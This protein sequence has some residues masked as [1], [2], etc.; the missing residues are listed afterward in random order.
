MSRTVC[1]LV[2][3]LAAAGFGAPRTASAEPGCPTWFP[4]L[5]CDREGRPQG[6]SAPMSMPYLFEDPFITTEVQAVAIGHDFPSSSV[7]D[8][9]HAAVLAVQARLAITDRLAFIATQ[10]GYTWLRADNPLVHD[11]DDFM[12]L[13]AGFKYA[14]V[15]SEEHDFVLTPSLRFQIPVGSG[16]LF[17][18]FGDGGFLLGT[19]LGWSPGDR[20]GIDLDA[21]H[22]I[23]G[24]GVFLP[25]DSDANSTYVHWNLHVGYRVLPF[26]VPFVAFNGIGYV[27]D[28]DGGNRIDVRGVGQLPLDTVQSVLG[29]GGFEGFDVANL[30]SDGV[31]GNHVATFAVGARF[32][33][34][35]HWSLGAA[36]ER[37]I[38]D[39]RDIFDQRATLMLQYTF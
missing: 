35:R 26:F 20:F 3:V 16:R 15:R 9:G 4:D 18:G 22:L 2:L 5:R 39:R 29:T 32:P 7:F 12:D 37:S 10:D 25:V 17:Q 33:V 13:M 24:T 31:A 19:S 28:G 14:L 34:A 27:A 11:H 30:G 1:A 38:S 6:W 21:L 36:W 8:G 23:A